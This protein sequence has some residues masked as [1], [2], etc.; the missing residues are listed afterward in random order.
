MSGQAFVA[1]LLRAAASPEPLAGVQSVLSGWGGCVVRLP[2][3]RRAQAERRREVAALLLRAGL[4]LAEAVPILAQR[5]GISDRHARR[6]LQIGHDCYT[7]CPN[8][9]LRSRRTDTETTP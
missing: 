3:P 5:V 9:V 8:G 7:Q 1:E 2:V 4:D 6:L